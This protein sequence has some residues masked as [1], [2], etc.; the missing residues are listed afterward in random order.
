MLPLN[1]NWDCLWS[2]IFLNGHE[3]SDIWNPKN[4]HFRLFLA[5]LSYRNEKNPIEIDKRCASFILEGLP[6]YGII[7]ISQIRAYVKAKK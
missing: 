7:I 3:L 1:N 2:L 5:I 4:Y 6:E